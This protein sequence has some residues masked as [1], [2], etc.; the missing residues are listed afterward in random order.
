MH[1]LRQGLFEVRKTDEAPRKGARARPCVIATACPVHS[2]NKPY[3]PGSKGSGC[4]IL[5]RIPNKLSAM[6]ENLW[7]GMIFNKPYP[8]PTSHIK[9][10]TQYR[11]SAQRR[12]HLPVAPLQ[13]LQ[14]L[15]PRP[16]CAAVSTRPYLTEFYDFTP[17]EGT[18][19]GF[20]WSSVVPSGPRRFCSDELFITLVSK[21]CVPCIE[22]A[23]R[24]KRES[25]TRPT[26]RTIVGVSLGRK[27]RD[28]L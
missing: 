10:W 1:H 5:N 21:V 27:W 12:T 9:R 15:L 13:D 7:G 4:G 14:G 28:L 6:T 16:Q 8:I 17:E 24:K 11:R 19:L 2:F 22:Q 20:Q 23:R 26:L 3:V 25:R 18:L